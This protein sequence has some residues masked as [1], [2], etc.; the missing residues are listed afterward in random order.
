MLSAAPFE[1]SGSSLYEDLRL[2]SCPEPASRS[3]FRSPV[4]TVRFRAAVTGSSFPTVLFNASWD[5]PQVRLACGSS[6]RRFAPTS[7]ISTPPARCPDF[8]PSIPVSTRTGSSLGAFPA[9]STQSDLLPG[10][11]PSKTVRSPAA[12]RTRYAYCGF[13]ALG[14]LRFRRLAVPQTSWNHFNFPPPSLQSQFRF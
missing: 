10:S 3:G 12:P 6:L 7:A 8:T 1:S 2:L 11:S 4:T 14:P 9:G 5:R 13:F